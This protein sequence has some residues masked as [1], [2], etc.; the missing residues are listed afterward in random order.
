M[1]RHHEYPI[2]LAG[3]TARHALRMMLDHQAHPIEVAECRDCNHPYLYHFAGRAY[4]SVPSGVGCQSCG[5][6]H[7]CV[8]DTTVMQALYYPKHDDAD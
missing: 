2:D 4:G 6:G 7:R 1:P 3:I 5:P 8:R